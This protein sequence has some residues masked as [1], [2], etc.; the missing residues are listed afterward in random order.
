MIFHPIPLFLA[1]LP[2]IPSIMLNYKAIIKK[3]HNWN[4]FHPSKW[5]CAEVSCK[6][7]T[8]EINL[9]DKI[10]R[11]LFCVFHICLSEIER[12]R[13]KIQF[14][15]SKNV[16]FSLCLFSAFFQQQKRA[17]ERKNLITLCKGVK[18]ENLFFFI[19]FSSFKMLSMK[20][21][22]GWR[23]R[24]KRKAQREMERKINFQLV[25]LSEK[26]S[27][28]FLF[29][30]QHTRMLKISLDSNGKSCE[31]NYV[32]L[33]WKMIG[34]KLGRKGERIFAFLEMFAW[35]IWGFL[36][37]SLFPIEDFHTTTKI[38]DNFHKEFQF[39]FNSLCC[40]ESI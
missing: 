12:E 18:A 3:S 38:Y 23:C 15:S 5:I 4:F 36:L 9:P 30:Q 32:H 20:R 1:I 10:S 26:F 35:W 22:Y 21:I 28:R 17:N 24:K 31:N 25:F 14:S 29:A 33:R 6:L 39:I 13:K 2:S 27:N 7:Y 19:N 34:E 16:N 37:P 40:L 11:Q 8:K